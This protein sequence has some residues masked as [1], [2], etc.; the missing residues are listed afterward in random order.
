MTPFGD[1]QITGLSS[2]QAVTVPPGAQVALVSVAAQAVRYR[3]GEDPTASLGIH[4]NA[5]DPPQWLYNLTD[6][7]FIEETAGAVID[8]QF[9][10]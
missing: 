6:L 8:I 1:G 5:D 3:Y 9:F 7:R 2:V 4:L 10:G